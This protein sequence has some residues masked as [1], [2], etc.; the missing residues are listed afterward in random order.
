MPTLL[1]P[2]LAFSLTYIALA[3]P[4]IANTHVTAREGTS[5]PAKIPS[6]SWE[7]V[8]TGSEQQFRGLAAVGDRVVWLAGSQGTVL[9][10][11]DSGAS[12]DSV[13]P[14]LSEEDAD[15]EFRDVHAWSAENA[16]IL[17]IGSGP[18][19]RVYLTSDGGL[20][21]TQTFTN[22]EES[23][24]Y[25]CLDFE[26]EKRGLAVSDPVDG[27]FRLIETLNGGSSWSIVNPRGMPP[28]WEGEFGFSAS[29]TCLTTTAGRWYSAS[30]GVDPGRVFSSG[31]GHSWE[32]ANSSIAGGP[33][34]GVFSVQFLNST[35]GIALGG[36]FENPGGNI[37]NAAWSADAG[38]TWHPALGF[39]GG[40]RS[41]SSWVPG[42]DDTAIAVGPL[43]SD[44]T[45]DG[46]QTW[47]PFDNGSFDSVDCDMK[48][49]CWASGQDGRVGRLVVQYGAR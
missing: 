20:T 35:Y 9:R 17:S 24:F 36:D 7:L 23:A 26:D 13:G 43:G 32:V 34:G 21:W 19:S 14:K 44:L 6:F 15:L 27:V 49:S 33:A 10:S 2:L 40:Y 29:G 48:Q 3:H 8:P 46:G 18:E 4:T 25:N 16:V 39:P 41:S 30:G 11:V 38:A 37:S 12:W 22:E 42:F 1:R 47:H 31:D 45:I 28:A 5:N